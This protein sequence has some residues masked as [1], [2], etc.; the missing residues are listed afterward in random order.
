MNVMV[1]LGHP[2]RGSFNHG[3]A[4]A[5]V[6]TLREE[7]HEVWFH[8]LYRER[9]DPVLPHEEISVGAKLDPLVALHCRELAACDGLVIIHPNWWGQPPAIL[10]GWIDRTFRSG[11]AYHFSSG[12]SGEGI[13]TPLLRA[14]EALVLNTTDTPAERESAAFGDPLDTQWKNCVLRYCGIR[15]V[16]RKT[17]GVVVTSAP[18]QRC[19]WLDDVRF[20]VKASFPRTLRPAHH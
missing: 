5:V 1:V 18:E 2:R 17:Y 8:D 6:A 4:E 15:S 16:V 9:F 11:V 3:I 13:P 10:K 7:E 20:Q 12:D 19:R 14:H